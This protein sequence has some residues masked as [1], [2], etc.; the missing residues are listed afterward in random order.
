MLKRPM[1]TAMGAAAFAVFAADTFAIDPADATQQQ[2][3]QQI[4]LW[5]KE[6]ADRILKQDPPEIIYGSPL[7]APQE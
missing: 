6:D 2:I 3:Q 1:V 7:M 5:E 4:R